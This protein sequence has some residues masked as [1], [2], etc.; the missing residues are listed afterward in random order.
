M[1]VDCI[2]HVPPTTPL[3]SHHLLPPPS[4]QRNFP[5]CTI[6]HTPRLPEHCVE[7]A[8]LLLWPKENP[9]GDAAAIDG[10]DPAHIGWILERAQERAAEYGIAGVDYRLTQVRGDGGTGGWDW[11]WLAGEGRGGTVGWMFLVS[12]CYSG[13]T[14]VVCIE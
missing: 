7:Y 8:R 5:L 9:W 13:P 12:W 6:A 4:R 2:F 1:T 3:T 14:Q 11:R 10:D